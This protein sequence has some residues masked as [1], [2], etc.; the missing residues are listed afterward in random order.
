MILC[1]TESV[2]KILFVCTGNTCRSPMAEGLMK[3]HIGDNSAM[4][5]SSAGVAASASSPAS[6]E[7]R[8]ILLAHD[9]D[10]H[11][12][13]SRP[14]TTELIDESDYVFCMSRTH[15]EAILKHMPEHREKVLRVGE[16]LGLEDATDVFDPFGLGEHAYKEVEAQLLIALKNIS[17]FITENEKL[18]EDLES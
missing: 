3:K 2:C 18:K 15:R 17:V 9:V 1:V 4:E 8:N 7:T 12:F 6:I 11:S 16:F 13:R 14:V 5:V 10:F